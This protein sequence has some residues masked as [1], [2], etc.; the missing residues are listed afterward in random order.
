MATDARGN[1][2]I[3]C[4]NGTGFVKC[5]YAGSNF[6]EYIFPSLVGRPVLRSQAKIGEPR[7]PLESW[8]RHEGRARPSSRTLA[9]QLLPLVHCYIHYCSSSPCCAFHPCSLPFSP[10]QPVCPCSPRFRLLL[11]AHGC[12]PHYLLARSAYPFSYSRHTRGQASTRLRI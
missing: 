6:P 8:R 2:V 12:S 3:V 5:G 10:L 9:R 4:D 11:P 1:K 7:R